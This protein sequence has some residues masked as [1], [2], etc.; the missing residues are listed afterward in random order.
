MKM[1]CVF[2]CLLALVGCSHVVQ[3][4]LDEKIYVV[5]RERESVFVLDHGNEKHIRDLGNLNH[6]TMKFVGDYGFVLARDGYLSKIDSKSD[7]LIKKVKIGK[8]GI[9]IT[10]IQDKVV[11]VNYDPNS[12]VILD[13]D[14]NIVKTIETESRN[15]GVK[16]YKNL[17]VFSLMDKNQIWVLDA[18]KNFEV[19]KKFDD[20]GLLPFDA[21]I[22]DQ[23]YIVGFF[24]EA[25][26][27]ILDVESLSYKKIQLKDKQ[28]KLV[29]K[30]PHF[31]YWGVVEN[32]AIVPIVS[33]NKLLA[34]DLVTAQPIK[35]IPLIGSPV[36]AAVSPD[37]KN[38]IVNYSGDKENFVS[39]VDLRK[40][41][42]IKDLEVGKRVMHLRYSQKSD[43]V[44][45][46]TYF[47]NSLRII[48]AN[49]WS[50]LN[51]VKVA[52]P[53]GI[54]LDSLKE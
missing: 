38:L 52:T 7:Q 33:D 10:F 44:Y 43:A 15:V 13:Q 30:V 3:R 8:S 29:L 49:D 1:S 25:A 48:D 28:D 4:P 2:L 42:K 24:N 17:L 32:T 9:G 16:T 35:E 50:V 51:E 11:V 21:L 26:V 14:L 36:F 31:G 27:G 40:M 20:I 37:K 54:F 53:S 47:D 46:T 41:E 22:K 19:L 34:L 12:V 5:E 23:K 18:S 6:A 39:V 45:V